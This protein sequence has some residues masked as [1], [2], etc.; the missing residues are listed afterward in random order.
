MKFL[1][2]SDTHG[3][4]DK[5]EEIVKL[6]R[7]DVD[8]IFHTGDSEAAPTDP[9]WSQVDGVVR[10][11]MDFSADYPTDRLVDTPVG[12]VLLVHGHLD[13]VNQSNRY[14]LA[15]GRSVGASFIFHGHTHVLY[16]QMADGIL[17]ANPGS[18]FQSRGPHPERTYMIVEIHTNHIHINYYDD[19]NNPLPHL[20]FDFDR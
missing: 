4:Y 20:Q 12:K 8:Y 17:I 7:N 13:Q 11:N 18:V 19:Q 15:K 1:V 3:R 10:G 6:W 16:A 2:M 9:I 14:L 5:V